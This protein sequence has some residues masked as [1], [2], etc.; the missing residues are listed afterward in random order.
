MQFSVIYTVDAHECASGPDCFKP[1]AGE[2]NET[3]A[4]EGEDAEYAYL[5][6]GWENG[7]HR[8]WCAVLGRD[9]FEAFLSESG[10]IMEDVETMG[11]IGAPG[12]GIGWAPAFSFRG[13]DCDTI[14]NAYVCPV[15]ECE[16][17]SGASTT[18][19]S[20]ERL[21]RVMLKLYS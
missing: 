8:K 7:W 3:E 13:D 2:W 20:W 19:K 16:V 1:S 17:K 21:K 4:S 18:E 12:F 6:R 5:E 11:M 15:P 9:D 14:S 10:L